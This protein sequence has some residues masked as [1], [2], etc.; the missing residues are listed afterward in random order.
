MDGW[1]DDLMTEEDELFGGDGLLPVVPL[2]LEVL[3]IFGKG[4]QEAEIEPGGRPDHP[5]LVL[6]FGHVLGHVQGSIWVRRM[7]RLIAA[8]VVSSELAEGRRSEILKELDVEII[9]S[10]KQTAGV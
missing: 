3:D 1:M 10:Y 6:G 8:V 9:Q 4:F 7:G 2:G 5:L